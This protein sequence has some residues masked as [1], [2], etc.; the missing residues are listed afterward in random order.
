MAFEDYKNKPAVVIVYDGDGKGKTSACLGL[1]VRALGSGF[2]VAF[3]QFIKYWTVGE[4]RFIE[5]IQSLYGQELVFHRGG[6]GF[7]QAGELSAAGVSD[8]EHR[9]AAAETYDF[10]LRAAASGDYGLVVCDE[11]NNAV[12][13]GLLTEEQLENLFKRRHG[14]TSLCLSGRDFPKRLLKYVDIATEMKKVKHHFD[15]RFLANKGIDY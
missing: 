9:Q 14:S 15:D 3:A 7:F 5:R 2:K 11:I 10:A 13:D 4:H 8:E 6:R 12:A 1:T